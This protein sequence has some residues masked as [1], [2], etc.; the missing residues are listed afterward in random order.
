VHHPVGLHPSRRSPFVE[1][2]GLLQAHALGALGG[3]DRPVCPCGLPETGC[4]HSVW[5]YAVAVFPVPWAV[6][7]PLLLTGARKLC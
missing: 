3:V 2:E 4:R 5:S 6:E 1:H 7:V